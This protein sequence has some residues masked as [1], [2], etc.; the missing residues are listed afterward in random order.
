APIVFYPPPQASTT[1]GTITNIVCSPPSG[2]SFPVGPTIVTC[3]AYNSVGNSN[4]CTFTVNV[5]ADTTP[6]VID[7]ACL[8]YVSHEALNVSGCQAVVP[9]L[10]NY[11][12]FNCV[13]E[14]CCLGT[15]VQNPTPGT[16]VGPG[17]TPITWTIFDC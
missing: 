13:S 6:P 5:G 10:C 8:N 17:S 12:S 3:T 2:S 11:L 9:D 7:C 1:C 14:D 16:P 4:S 15:C